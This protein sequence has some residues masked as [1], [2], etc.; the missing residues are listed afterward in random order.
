MVN[1]KIVVL[2]DIHFGAY[3]DETGEDETN[4]DALQKCL[5]LIT[6]EI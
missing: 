4:T 5:N 2:S 3:F 1:G 6:N